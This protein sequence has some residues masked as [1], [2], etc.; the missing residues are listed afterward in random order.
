MRSVSRSLGAIYLA[1]LALFLSFDSASALVRIKDIADLRGMRSNQLVGYGIVIGLNG[2]GD[3]MRNSPFTEQSLQSMLER[4]GVNVRESNLRSR[5]VA[6]VVVTAEL[7]PFIG[8]GARIDVSVG[9]LGDAASLQGGTLLVTPLM[10]ADGN[11]YAVAQGSVSVSGFAAA[12]DAA[13]LTQGVPTAGSVS[14]GALIE[15]TLPDYFSSLPQLVLELKNP[16]FKTAVRVTDAINAFSLNRYGLK[17]ASELDYRS[18][19]VQR[20]AGIS[21]V[22]FISQIEGLMVQPD[23]P[24]RVVVDERTGTVVIGQNVRIST[25][26]V[27]HG[28]LTV[29]VSERPEVSQPS[30]FA[31]QGETVVVPRTDID[32]VQEDGQLQLIGGTDL[33][34]LVRGLNRIGLKPSGI[35]AILQAIKQAGALQATL[36]VK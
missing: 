23:T 21:S 30:P 6:A 16:D 25:V 28:N 12:G 10:G 2:S 34:T 36:V 29:R 27:T 1:F 19:Q 9:S 11:V 17:L 3:T 5:N 18:V 13:S 15:K 31:Q 24:A 4:M 20:P 35:I 8:N 26:A 7:P 33:Q 14:N 22:R 32:V